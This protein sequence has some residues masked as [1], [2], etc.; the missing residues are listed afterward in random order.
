MCLTNVQKIN[1]KYF[2]DFSALFLNV[3]QRKK[4]NIF[5]FFAEPKNI[6]H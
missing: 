2:I 5:L 4:I 6:T 1:S 3:H